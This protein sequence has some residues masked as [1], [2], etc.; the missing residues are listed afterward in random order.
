[1]YITAMFNTLLIIVTTFYVFS[2]IL[3]LPY[4]K[5]ATQDVIASEVLMAQWIESG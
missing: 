1:M 5:T 2:L 3:C 4:P